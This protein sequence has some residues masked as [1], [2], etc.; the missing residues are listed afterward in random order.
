MVDSNLRAL[1][2]RNVHLQD[3]VLVAAICFPRMMPK[4]LKGQVGNG[5]NAMDDLEIVLCYEL[6]PRWIDR[7]RRWQE[8]FRYQRSVMTR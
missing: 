1:G 3:S 8:R 5:I 4:K 6:F 2:F 7:D